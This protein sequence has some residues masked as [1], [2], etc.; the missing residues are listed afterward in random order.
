MGCFKDSTPTTDDEVRAC[1]AAAALNRQAAH[2]AQRG[3][4]SNRI[5]IT[6]GNRSCAH[7]VVVFLLDREGNLT[8]GT[9]LMAP[10]GPAPMARAIHEDY[11]V[12]L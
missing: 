1:L 11:T 10:M 2:A 9:F 12:G 3:A 6:A 4:S 8:A 7:N 5:L